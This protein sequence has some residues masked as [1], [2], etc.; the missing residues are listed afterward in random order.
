MTRLQFSQFDESP[1]GHLIPILGPD[2]ATHEV[3][4]GKAFL[5]D[6]LPRNLELSTKTWTTVNGASAA[7]ARLDGAAR[8]IPSPALLRR[9]ALRREAQSTSALEGTYAPS[10][11]G[12]SRHVRM[13]LT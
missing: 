5:P 4:E 11:L 10:S 8:L 2:P 7:L 13:P 6:P 12:L 9:P 1:I 3:V